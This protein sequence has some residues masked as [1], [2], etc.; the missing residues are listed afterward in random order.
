MEFPAGLAAAVRHRRPYSQQA[1]A[2]NEVKA[3]SNKETGFTLIELIVV[4]V[5]L[6]ILAATAIPRFSDLSVN[7]RV[8]SADGVEGA[9]RSASALAHAQALVDGVTSGTVTMEGQSV[10]IT[11]GYADETATGIGTA[12]S[13]S[14]DSIVCAAGGAGYRCTIDAITSCYVEYDV[15]TTPPSI[16][17]NA[18]TAN[19]Q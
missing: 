7:A 16:S 5:I 12:M 8:A 14:G 13:T 15:A 18:S 9:M 6:G 10:D 1:A 4:I 3:M 19:C 2:Y 17:N 11:G